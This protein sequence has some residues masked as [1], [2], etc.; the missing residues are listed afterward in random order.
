[1]KWFFKR[2]AELS[3]WEVYEILHLRN[4]V[5][6]VDQKCPYQDIDNKDQ[7]SYHLFAEDERKTICAYL[8]ILDK[9]QTFDQLSIGRVIIRKDQR[10]TGLGKRMMLRA[11][12]FVEN[13]LKEHEIKIEAQAHLQN[14]YSAVGFTPCSDRYLEDEIPHIDMVY[15]TLDSSSR[16]GQGQ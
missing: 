6:I 16:Q 3:P 15:S 9:G 5:F 13:T 4:E 10:S 2:F 14:F 12:E 8:R 1:M 11:I 7:Y